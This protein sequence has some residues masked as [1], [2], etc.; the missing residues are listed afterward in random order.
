MYLFLLDKN[1]AWY[2]NIQK[3]PH[4]GIIGRLKMDNIEC[5]DVKCKN[6]R[7]KNT[8]RSV[9]GKRELVNR[10]NRIT[11]QLAG[12]KN[13]IEGDRY[14]GDILIQVGAA[15]KAL[16]NLGYMIFTE[17]MQSCVTEKI[18]AG[19]EGI[20]EETVSLIKQLK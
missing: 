17:H 8:P 18:K 10:I 2:Y 3:I 9:E 12:I 4:K 5:T 1:S 14:C 20:I 15:E 11:G 6:C 19:E 13:M 7:M 16:Q